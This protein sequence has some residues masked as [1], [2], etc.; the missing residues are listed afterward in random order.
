MMMNTAM[1]ATSTTTPAAAQPNN[2]SAPPPA[3]AA[4][5]G[6]PVQGDTMIFVP[7]AGLGREQ[8]DKIG[9]DSTGPSTALSAKV[10]RQ[11]DGTWLTKITVPYGEQRG[12]DATGGTDLTTTMSFNSKAQ[13]TIG[14]RGELQVSG[15]RIDG[16]FLETR[17]HALKLPPPD[18]SNFRYGGPKD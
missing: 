15:Q 12:S 10:T 1:S 14:A 7:A 11:N 9:F 5:A 13:P 18:Y 17:L 8:M 2:D 3:Q 16:N 4:G 6:R